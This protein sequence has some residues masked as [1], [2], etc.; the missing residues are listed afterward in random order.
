MNVIPVHV[1]PQ[2]ISMHVTPA[3]IA[4]LYTGMD[5]IN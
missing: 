2:I 3:D 1:M 5:P 4:P